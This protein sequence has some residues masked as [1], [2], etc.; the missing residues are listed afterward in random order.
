MS[1]WWRETLWLAVPLGIGF[2]AVQY[3]LEGPLFLL[4]GLAIFYRG[5]RK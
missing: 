4:M 3:K 5:F 1:A 2:V